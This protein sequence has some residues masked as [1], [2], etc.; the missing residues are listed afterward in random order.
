MRCAEE[1]LD[2]IFRPPILCNRIRQR[3]GK[4]RNRDLIRSALLPATFI[5]SASPKDS[6]LLIGELY[7]NIEHNNKSM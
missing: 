5:T 7:A 1:D 2:E 3:R 4:R 6:D